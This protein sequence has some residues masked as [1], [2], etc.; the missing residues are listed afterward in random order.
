MD[1]IFPSYKEI[2]RALLSLLYIS[3]GELEA[4]ETYKPLA[5]FFGLTERARAISRGEYYGNHPQRAWHNQVEY[6]RRE[7]K[8]AGYLDLSAPRGVWRLNKQGF[9]AA[10]DI[11]SDHPGLRSLRQAKSTLVALTPEASDKNEPEEEAVRSLCT[12]YRI[13][14]DTQLAREIK[15]IHNYQ[16]QV[17]HRE[18][19]QLKDGKL[20]AEVHH[21]KPWLMLR[22]SAEL[23]QTG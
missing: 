16:C 20:Y 7:L 23:A 14:R 3:G 11:Y 13:L 5:D 4:H 15:Y 18:G 8:K 17:C 19:L 2:E 21:I 22:T 1:R 10:D 6:G 9:L 12:V